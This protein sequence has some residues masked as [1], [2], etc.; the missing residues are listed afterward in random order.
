LANQV[1]SDASSSLSEQGV[2]LLLAQI[3]R[4][5]RNLVASSLDQISVHVGQ[6][7]VVHRLAIEEGITQSRLAEAL[8]VDAS[9]VTKTLLRL[10]RGGVVERR[11]DAADARIWRV[12]LTAHGRS[13]VKPVADIWTQA[14]QRLLQNLSEAERALLRRLLMQVLANLSQEVHGLPPGETAK[15]L[16]SQGISVVKHASEE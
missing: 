4:A 8:C 13:L 12:Y 14:E 10:E 16:A 2:G 1:S 11:A 9:T 5:H 15:Y 3:C 6:D 7:H